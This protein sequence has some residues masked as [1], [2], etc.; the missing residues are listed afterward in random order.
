MVVEARDLHSPLGDPAASPK[1]SA[2]N[3]ARRLLDRALEA[4]ECGR[5]AGLMLVAKVG[6]RRPR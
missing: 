3:S 6:C 2:G 1:D 5:Y 4:G